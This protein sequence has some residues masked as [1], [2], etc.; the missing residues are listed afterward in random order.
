[1]N[2]RDLMVNFGFVAMRTRF[3]HQT[4]HRPVVA[5]APAP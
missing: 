4:I 5:A 1:M 2:G 3:M